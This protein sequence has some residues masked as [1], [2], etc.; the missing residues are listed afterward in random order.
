[1]SGDR[2]REGAGHR[3][4]RGPD[5]TMESAAESGELLGRGMVEG[6][7]DGASVA[8]PQSA[9]PPLATRRRAAA[10]LRDYLALTKPRIIALLLVTTVATMFVADPAG[11]GL[12]TIL[13]TIVGC[14]LDVG[15]A[16]AINP[17][18]ERG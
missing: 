11:P 13:W 12:A 9:T 8:L 6:A 14:C 16:G 15:G 5:L 3:H 18:L 7:A 4:P 10:V 1:Q 2:Q 17:Q